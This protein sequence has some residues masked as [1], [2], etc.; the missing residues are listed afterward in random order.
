MLF[1]SG[2]PFRVPVSLRISREDKMSLLLSY[3]FFQ[4]AYRVPPVLSQ[5]AQPTGP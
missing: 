3:I 4:Q 5:E 1:T 2:I